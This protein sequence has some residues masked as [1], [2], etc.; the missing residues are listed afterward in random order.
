MFHVCVPCVHWECMVCTIMLLH[1]CAR[2][3][4]KLR[5]FCCAVHTVIERADVRTL[6]HVLYMRP[7]YHVECMDTLLYVDEIPVLTEGWRVT[8]EIL[9][10]KFAVSAQYT[11]LPNQFVLPNQNLTNSNL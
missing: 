5:H 11:E 10:S 9:G 2:Q 8:L 3:F 4:A 6:H 1:P 7:L